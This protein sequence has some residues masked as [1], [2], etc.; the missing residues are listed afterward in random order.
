[1][2]TGTVAGIENATVNCYI[3]GIDGIRKPLKNMSPCLW[4]D[5]GM[6]HQ[7]FKRSFDCE[8]HHPTPR[9]VPG[10]SWDAI[11]QGKAA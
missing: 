9:E 7:I 11:D 2:I 5:A 4:L 6:G 3:G 10:V 1:M 8:P